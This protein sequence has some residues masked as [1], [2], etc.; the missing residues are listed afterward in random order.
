MHGIQK[1]KTDICIHLGSHGAS[2]LC[3]I[4]F[5][6]RCI[7]PTAE[8][9]NLFI[10]V[11]VTPSKGRR[12][13][14]NSNI[15]F[16]CLSKLLIKWDIW[17]PSDGL[18][19]ISFCLRFDQRDS[20]LSLKLEQSER[21]WLTSSALFLQKKTKFT[22]SICKP[23]N[24]AVQSKVS[25]ESYLHMKTTYKVWIMISNGPELIGA[26]VLKKCLSHSHTWMV[27]TKMKPIIC[28]FFKDFSFHDCFPVRICG[29]SR[30][31]EP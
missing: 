3:N 2:S 16:C 17:V 31:S 12:K 7:L 9:M 13:C 18:Q 19:A 22:I 23:G 8:D 10:M 5:L 4:S 29:E 11:T 15:I 30:F 20:K 25:H 24:T 21:K 1:K 6:N 26:N 28:L 14:P 27:T